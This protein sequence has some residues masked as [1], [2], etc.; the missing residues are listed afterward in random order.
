MLMAAACSRLVEYAASLARDAESYAI[1]SLEKHLDEFPLV[2]QF[3]AE[4]SAPSAQ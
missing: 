3:I 2:I 1:G 4:Q